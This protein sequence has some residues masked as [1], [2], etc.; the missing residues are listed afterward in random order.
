MRSPVY[1]LSK[2]VKLKE[3]QDSKFQVG[4][5]Y[6]QGRWESSLLGALL[7]LEDLDNHLLFVDEESSD[8]SGSDGAAGK[9]ATVR[10]GDLNTKISNEAFVINPCRESDK[11]FFKFWY[12]IARDKLKSAKRICPSKI[13]IRTFWKIPFEEFDKNMF[14]SYK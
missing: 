5:I 8:D 3:T 14:F 13:K 6:S 10:S 11:L 1:I 4:I 7:G 9:G 2:I 12:T